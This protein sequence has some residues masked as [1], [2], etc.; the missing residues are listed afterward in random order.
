MEKIGNKLPWTS[1]KLAKNTKERFSRV[2][3]KVVEN[4]KTTIRSRRLSLGSVSPASKRGNSEGEQSDEKP[5]KLADNR[6]SPK[7]DKDTASKSGLP[8]FKKQ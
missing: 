5:S 2:K 4:L 7:K 8:Q 3:N 6:P 1:H